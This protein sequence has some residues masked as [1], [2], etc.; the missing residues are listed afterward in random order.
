MFKS[1]EPP[2]VPCAPTTTSR[3]ISAAER[4]GAFAL[5]ASD[6]VWEV[7]SNERACTLVIG[8]LAEGRSAHE[9]AEVLCEA[10]LAKGSEDNVAAVLVMLS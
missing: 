1:T 5:L 8:A 7:F 4:Q 6:G 10:A 2:L 3:A 9:A